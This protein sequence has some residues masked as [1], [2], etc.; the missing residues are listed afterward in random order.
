MM[1]QL[2]KEILSPS[3]Q[4]KVQISNRKDG[5]YTT[6]VFMWKEEYGYE[7]WSPIKKELTLA[8]TEEGAMSLAIE[9]LRE[10]SGEIINL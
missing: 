2:L 6:E 5:L 10:Y 3:N 1:K 7:Y 8:Q 9:H 4:Y